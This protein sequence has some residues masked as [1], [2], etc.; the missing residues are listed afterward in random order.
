MG[1][2]RDCR[3]SDSSSR[4]ARRNSVLHGNLMA[5]R[6]L[7]SDALPYAN[8][9]LHLGHMVESVQTDV[10][11]RA[12]NAMGTECIFICAD[13]THG[14]PIEI[15][16][17]KA[18]VAPEEWIARIQREH[19]EDYK[20]F[21]IGFD[22]FYTTHSPENEHHT[23]RIHE[24]LRAD[25]AIETRDVQQVYCPVD[26]PFRPDRYFRGEGPVTGPKDQ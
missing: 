24:A 1:R 23:R 8:G 17:R 15:S 26:Q 2:I 21:E 12:M 4:C 25:G 16:A 11:V 19:A 6:M 13:D 22:L 9:S 18:G 10:F 7:A 20:S 5:S 3:W 14:T